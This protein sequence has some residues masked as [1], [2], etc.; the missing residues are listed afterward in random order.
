MFALE[1]SVKL[2]QEGG[3]GIIV[4][5]RKEGRALGEVVKFRVYNAR[6]NQE[7]GDRADQYFAQ[8]E[9]IRDYQ[10]LMSTLCWIRRKTY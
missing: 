9:S 6:E 1:E 5:F 3:V 2:A 4:Y 7:G 10:E 8:T